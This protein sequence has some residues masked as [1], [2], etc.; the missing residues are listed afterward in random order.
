MIYG[1][2]QFVTEAGADNEG[3]PSTSLPSAVSQTSIL[4][5][6]FTFKKSEDSAT[7]TSAFNQLFANAGVTTHLDLAD[8]G[9]NTHVEI[10]THIDEAREVLTTGREYFVRTDGNDSNTGLVDSD[11]GAFLTIQKVL[12]TMGALDVSIYDVTT[13]IRD[14]TYNITTGLVLKSPVGSGQVF[15]LGNSS[16]QDAVIISCAGTHN[17][18]QSLFSTTTRFTIRDVQID[19]NFASGVTACVAI[20]G[21]QKVVLDGCHVKDNFRICTIGQNA[22]L[23]IETTSND[24]KIGAVQDDVFLIQ[25]GGQLDITGESIDTDDLAVGGFTEFFNQLKAGRVDTRGSTFTTQSMTGRQ[26]NVV[27]N[28]VLKAGGTV[29][30]IP[31]D[32]SG[33]TASGGVQT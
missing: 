3:V 13:Q 25:D 15:I 20:S 7:I 16:D 4:A 5:S 14:G 21:S 2:A 28:S 17:G 1:R 30:A 10:D 12:D 23:Q 33:V 18:I 6:R 9:V 19:C 22:T 8:I 31:G 24:F 11:I 29:S 32:T 27:E 26:F